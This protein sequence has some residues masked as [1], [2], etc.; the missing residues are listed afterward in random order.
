MFYAA[1]LIPKK[2]CDRIKTNRGD[3]D[4]LARLCRAGEL[5]AIHMPDPEDEAVRDLVRARFAAMTDQRQARNRLKGF[6]LRLGGRY[7][8]K[9][10]WNDAPLPFPGAGFLAFQRSTWIT[11][12][13]VLRTRASV[14]HWLRRWRPNARPGSPEASAG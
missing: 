3:S 14:F 13:W 8:G 5:T 4:Q 12:D 10:S 11:S 2:S 7:T 6:Q 1:S 9:S